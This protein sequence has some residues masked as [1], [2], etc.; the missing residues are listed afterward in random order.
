MT[1]SLIHCE[2][3]AR[4]GGCPAISLTYEEQ[5]AKKH[6]FVHRAFALFTEL[7][8]ITVAPT[9]GAKP[10]V[11]Y[12]TRAKFVTGKDGAIGLYSPGTHE[13]Q[14]VEQCRVIAPVISSGAAALRDILRNGNSNPALRTVLDGGALHAVDLRELIQR[15][16][17]AKLL[18]TLVL[19]KNA[20]TDLQASQA[21]ERLVDKEIAKSAAASWH[22]GRSIQMLGF[23]PKI[24]AGDPEPTDF[25]VPG[26]L[27]QIAAPGAFVQT[28]R[29]TATAIHDRIIQSLDER[30]LRSRSLRV[31]ELYA[32][33]GALG[34][35]LAS[36]GAH[37]TCVE[38]YRPAVDQIDQAARLQGINTVTAV[39]QDA[40]DYALECTKKRRRFDCVVVNPPRRGLD[41]RL[42]TAMAQLR[43]AQVVYVSCDP[44]TLA[45]DTAELFALGYRTDTAQPFDMIPLSNEVETLVVLRLENLNDACPFAG[46]MLYSN[47]EFAVFQHPIGQSG[48]TL[49]RAGDAFVPDGDRRPVWLTTPGEDMAGLTIV[50]KN[51]EALAKLTSPEVTLTIEFEAWVRGITRD[52]GKIA[53]PSGGFAEATTRYKRLAVEG[54]HSRLLITTNQGN[55]VT[56]RHHLANIGYPV[57]GDERFGDAATNTFC[58]EKLGLRRVAMQ[59]TKL[60]LS[61]MVGGVEQAQSWSYPVCGALL[62]LSSR[63]L[64]RSLSQ[65]AKDEVW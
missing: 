57:L 7:A 3:S 35:R 20:C 22:D 28:H 51:R 13:V 10:I 43:P 1:E 48:Q 11:R 9:L 16:R 54:G 4:C 31:L 2:H 14:D 5:L 53:R 41:E 19:R 17:T 49:D 36:A 29:G 39:A 6:G 15:D 37:V 21:C 64:G 8:Q 12:R 40:A 63:L 42:L 32:G 46:E 55:S 52:K 24:L 58:R 62:L 59:T 61:R 25:F 56:V 50:A 34:L 23:N 33:S 38:S 47:R 45:R 30:L 26:K 60:S 65:T 44:E 18:I 27:W